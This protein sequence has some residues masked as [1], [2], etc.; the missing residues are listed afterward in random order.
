MPDSPDRPD[1]A[2]SPL[3]PDWPGLSDND[4]LEV[5]MSDLPL[6]IEGSALEPRIADLRAELDS[7]DLRFPLNFYLS[8]EWFTPD[9]VSSIAI[10][11]YLAHPRLAQ[12]EK[13][14][15]LEVEGGDYEWCLRIL[16]HE[17][18]HAIDNAY[19]LR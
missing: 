6:R 9:G 7:R 19:G 5:R 8:D 15:M 14:Q 18:G 1:V 13:A 12:L 10:A 2:D 3:P 17:A 16:R 4:L 11:F